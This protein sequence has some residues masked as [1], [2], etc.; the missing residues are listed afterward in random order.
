[1]ATT[2]P[3]AKP[4]HVSTGRSGIQSNTMAY[5]SNR[6]SFLLK[7]NMRYTKRMNRET[8]R[9]KLIGPPF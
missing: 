4:N 3:H 2:M 5:V 9:T 6:R 8:R 7:E 1:M